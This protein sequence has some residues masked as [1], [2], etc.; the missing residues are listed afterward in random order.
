MPVKAL[1]P[2]IGNV[3]FER[4]LH[5]GSLKRISLEWK[6]STLF[7][8]LLL[9]TETITDMSEKQFLKTELILA[10]GNWFSG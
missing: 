8:T 6:P 1:F 2:S 5:S 3:F 4:I 9:I 10:S 7:G